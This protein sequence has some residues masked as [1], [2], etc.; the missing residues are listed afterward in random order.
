MAVALNCVCALFNWDVELK[1]IRKQLADL[2]LDDVGEQKAPEVAASI[3]YDRTCQENSQVATG[4]LQEVQAGP[5]NTPDSADKNVV[6]VSG[7][8]IVRASAYVEHN[9]GNSVL[10]S[11]QASIFKSRLAP[12]FVTV[13]RPLQER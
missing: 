9:K 8:M 13:P 3:T 7:E 2:F 11:A 6:S 12:R 1:K 4:T 5:A 10:I